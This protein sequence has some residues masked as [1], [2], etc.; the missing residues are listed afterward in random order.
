MD[1]PCQRNNHPILNNSSSRSS[2]SSNRQQDC[3]SNETNSVSPESSILSTTTNSTSNSNDTSI[4]I[5]TTATT[6]SGNQFTD[7]PNVTEEEEEE[8][9]QLP[10]PLVHPN[11]SNNNY[12]ANIVSNTTCNDTSSTS[13]TTAKPPMSRSSKV[14]AFAVNATSSGTPV[15]DFQAEKMRKKQDNLANTTNATQ[16]IIQA[17]EPSLRTLLAVDDSPISSYSNH[18]KVLLAPENCTSDDTTDPVVLHSSVPEGTAT[19]EVLE[20]NNL[21]SCE[22]NIS[23]RNSKTSEKVDLAS[24]SPMVKPLASVRAADE[25]TTVSDD[26]LRYSGVDS[27]QQVSI[28]QEPSHSALFRTSYYSYSQSDA[29]ELLEENECIMKAS[30]EDG[31][32]STSLSSQDSSSVQQ[33]STTITPPA[34]LGKRHFTAT[35]NQANLR[36]LNAFVVP[37]T[38][39]FV[40]DPNCDTLSTDV[41]YMDVFHTIDATREE[42]T[43]SCHAPNEPVSAFLAG[44]ELPLVVGT[45]ASLDSMDA[46]SPSFA[47]YRK[48]IIR[49]SSGGDLKYGGSH[50]TKRKVY[51]LCDGAFIC[52][53]RACFI[54]SLLIIAAVVVSLISILVTNQQSPSHDPKRFADLSAIITEHNVTSDSNLNLRGSPQ[55]NALTWLASYDAAQLSVSNPTWVIQRYILAVLYYSFNGGKWQNQYNFLSS[56]HECHW[57]GNW[58]DIYFLVEGVTCDEFNNTIFIVLGMYF[59]SFVFLAYI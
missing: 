59:A 39:P 36:T 18:R 30:S 29:E 44:T 8:E 34:T 12:D 35:F 27:L 49:S 25:M 1:D 16:L 20:D 24:T 33:I 46:E 26:T 5:P 47:V 13:C 38:N 7:L 21:S 51:I 17:K 43:T 57:N 48:N 50:D 58:N 45:P 28:G 40:G 52:R 19:V 3:D 37:P 15:A 11:N 2:G 55:N 53:Q 54:L 32:P 14:G 9:Q 31:Q 10:N 41:S 6:A 42:S 22:D 4:E 23:S 56:D